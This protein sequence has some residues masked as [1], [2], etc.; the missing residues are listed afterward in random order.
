MKLEITKEKV[1]E[2]ASKCSTAKETLKTLFPEVFVEDKSVKIKQKDGY[3]FDGCNSIL[4]IRTFDELAG[5]SFWISDNYN[6][7]IKTDPSGCL[8]LIPTK[9]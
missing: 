3:Y 4:N 1:L 6:W 5:K 9:K 7:K 2:A 8:C